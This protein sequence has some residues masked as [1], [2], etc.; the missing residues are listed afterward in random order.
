MKKRDLLFAGLLL[1]GATAFA[2]PQRT[3]QDAKEIFFQGFEGDFDEW[4]N[5]VVDSITVL[6]YYNNTKTGSPS[7][8]C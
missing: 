2:Q 1:I 3:S 8:R 4:S 7:G 5:E 6:Q